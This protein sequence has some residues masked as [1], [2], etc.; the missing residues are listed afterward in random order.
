MKEKQATETDE[1]VVEMSI[2]LLD[3]GWVSLL[4]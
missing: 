4:K 2:I 3:L 1:V